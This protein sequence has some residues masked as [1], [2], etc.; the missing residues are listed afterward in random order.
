MTSTRFADQTSVNTGSDGEAGG[1]IGGIET[2]LDAAEAVPGLVGD[3]DMG[4]E[5]VGG[6]DHFR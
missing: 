2:I 3:V 6:D 1:T 4:A 5:A